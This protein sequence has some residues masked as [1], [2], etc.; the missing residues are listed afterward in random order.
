MQDR[1]LMGAERKSHYIDPKAKLMTA[2]HEVWSWSHFQCP[3]FWE[4]PSKGGHALVALYT[5]GAMPLHKVTC[6]PRGHALGYVC[7]IL[8]IPSSPYTKLTVPIFSQ[9]SQL[10]ENDRTS[11]SLKEYLADI[12][13]CMGGRVAEQLGES[14][15]LLIHWWDEQ[16][17][18]CFDLFPFSLRVRERYQW[19][20][21]GH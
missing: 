9:T 4:R 10:P 3:L 18:L 12:D 21:F 15:S 13:V 6:V 7:H 8:V 1:I 5:E 17:I 11:I 16:L 19:S 2:Y 14:L 20:K